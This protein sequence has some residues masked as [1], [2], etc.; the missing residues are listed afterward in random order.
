MRAR[1]FSLVVAGGILSAGIFASAVLAQGG[2]G[3][4]QRGGETKKSAPPAKS[5]Q[6]PQQRQE[7]QRQA[8]PQVGDGH[9]PARGPARTPVAEQQRPQPAPQRGQ[10]PP[11]RT[12]D[13]PGH[14]TAPHVDVNHD[15]WVG[16]NIGP[17]DPNLHLDRPWQHGRF[18]GS[19][20]ASTV[21]RLRGGSRERF[22]VGGYFFQVAPYEYGY[23]DGW[24][25]DNDDIILYLDP[26]HDGWYLAYDVRLGTYVHVLY[27]GL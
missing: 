18:S 7:P 24:L 10:Q 22:N 13:M 6:Q 11:Q 9:I 20:G 16:H 5:P 23:S 12:A 25:W 15:R 14:P 8:R 2:R 19:I 21:W 3:E 27:L 17:R 4:P 1:H 26:D